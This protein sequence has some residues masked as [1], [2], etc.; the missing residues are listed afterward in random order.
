MPNDS[1]ARAFICAAREGRLADAQRILHDTEALDV[2]YFGGSRLET[3]LDVA[4][5]FGRVEVVRWLLQQ[6]GRVFNLA[7]YGSLSWGSNG[8]DSEDELEPSTTTTNLLADLALYEGYKALVADW[9][10]DRDS[11]LRLLHERRACIGSCY[12]PF[13]DPDYL[14]TQYSRD[15]KPSSSS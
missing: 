10:S 15:M 11:I 13:H 1:E 7:D 4:I 5:K 6:G 3:S 2:N 14:F 9:T 8:S 12:E